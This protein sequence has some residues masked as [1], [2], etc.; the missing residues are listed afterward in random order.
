MKDILEAAVVRKLEPEQKLLEQ[1]R[2]PQNLWML[3]TR[4]S[5]V[6]VLEV[7]TLNTP[8]GPALAGELL[9][10]AIAVRMSVVGT[11][12]SSRDPKPL[13]QTNWLSFFESQMWRRY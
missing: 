1:K 7:R 13:H 4:L 12:S 10:V 8:M 2:L 9:S 11:H 5:R 3:E 6:V